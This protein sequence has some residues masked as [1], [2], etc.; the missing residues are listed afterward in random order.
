M[1]DNPSVEFFNDIIAPDTADFIL[2]R[3]QDKIGIGRFLVTFKGDTD[4]HNDLEY[5]PADVI[6]LSKV[7]NKNFRHSRTNYV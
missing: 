4:E 3:L 1:T 6:D 2:K 5:S 7:R